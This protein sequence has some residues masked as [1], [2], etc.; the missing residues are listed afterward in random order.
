MYSI[1][2]LSS[3][4]KYIHLHAHSRKLDNP[5]PLTRK[6]RNKIIPTP[7]SLNQPSNY[8][9]FSHKLRYANCNM[10]L[11]HQYFKKTTNIGCGFAYQYTIC[12]VSQRICPYSF[13]R[14][15]TLSN[16]LLVSHFETN[17][18]QILQISKEKS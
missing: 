12:L 15:S 2:Y 18:R 17:L 7:V 8:I 5:Y 11:P 10:S 4:Q 14:V 3:Q 16:F 6:Q 9:C 1:T 13:L